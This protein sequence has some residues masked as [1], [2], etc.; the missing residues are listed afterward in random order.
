MNNEVRVKNHC[1]HSGSGRNKWNE[2]ESIPRKK[3][4]VDDKITA[5]FQLLTNKKTAPMSYR[6]E[7]GF[8]HR[9]ASTRCK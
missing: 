5:N 4:Q 1:C 7:S 3:L 2:F 8:F 6:I 9:T